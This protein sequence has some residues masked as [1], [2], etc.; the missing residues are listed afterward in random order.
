MTESP[1]NTQFQNLSN[2]SN[3]GILLNENDS[4]NL[5]SQMLN[6]NDQNRIKEAFISCFGKSEDELQ[7]EDNSGQN[8]DNLQNQAINKDSD[9]VQIIKATEV[10]K[11]DFPKDINFGNSF[12]SDYFVFGNENDKGILSFKNLDMLNNQSSTEQ[13]STS[14]NSKTLSQPVNSETNETRKGE[15]KDENNNSKCNEI[16]ANVQNQM[17][18]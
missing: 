8:E 3:G 7:V 15:N 13:R 2:D 4:V 11:E 5:V 14:I 1:F 9:K 12:T 17:L 18:K 10:S 16:C 6:S